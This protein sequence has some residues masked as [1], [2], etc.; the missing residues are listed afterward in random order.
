MTGSGK[1]GLCVTLLEEAAI[2]GIPAI[3]LDPKGDLGNLLLTFR[4]WA[5][6]TSVPG[7]M[8]RSP[9]AR[10]SF[11]T[12]TPP[13][14]RAVAKRPRRME[15]GRRPDRAAAARGRVRYLHAGQLRRAA[16][17]SPV[18]FR[19]PAAWPARRLRWIRERVS[20]AASSLLALVG[21]E[22]DPIQ[23]R[24]QHPAL[25]RLEACWQAG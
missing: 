13:R 21:I 17:R 25:E 23:S 2:D 9:L 5:R 19:R 11:S 18:F 12:T 16:A 1:T 20:A 3:V 8:R 4:S 15:P 22:A 14:S 6:P 10:G 24:E 7:W